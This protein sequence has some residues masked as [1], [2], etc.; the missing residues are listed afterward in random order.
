[1]ILNFPIK[2][3]LIGVNHFE[4]TYPCKSKYASNTND[5]GE[6]KNNILINL[7]LLYEFFYS[8]NHI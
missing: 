6:K 3:Y 2:V 5:S 4:N 8:L 1:M 7:A